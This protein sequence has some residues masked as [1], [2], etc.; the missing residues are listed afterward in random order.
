MFLSSGMCLAVDTCF[1]KLDYKLIFLR[2]PIILCLH[3]MSN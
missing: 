2:V 1:L 3:A